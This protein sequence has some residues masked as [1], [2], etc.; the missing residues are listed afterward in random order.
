MAEF[1]SRPPGFY[2]VIA[3]MVGSSTALVPFGFTNVVTYC[4]LQGCADCG[5]NAFIA[6]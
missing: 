6:G 1:L 2:F 5:T 4:H 3:A